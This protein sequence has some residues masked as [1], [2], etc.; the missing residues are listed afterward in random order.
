MLRSCRTPKLYTAYPLVILDPERTVRANRQ[1]VDSLRTT[2]D[3]LRV[4]LEEER[5]GN[6]EEIKRWQSEAAAM[7]EKAASA[8]SKV[9][10]EKR[11]RNAA[12]ARAVSM[13]AG[14][15]G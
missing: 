12:E 5:R 2:C 13:V 9:E 11:K 6:A 1:E 7:K 4:E 10:E 3:A 8:I 14:E 15:M